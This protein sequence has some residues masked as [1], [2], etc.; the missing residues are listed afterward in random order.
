[1][2][3]GLMPCRPGGRQQGRQVSGQACMDTCQGCLASNTRAGI[4]YW[5]PC[6][7][8]RHAG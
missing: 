3:L 1:L 8:P 7:E 5:Q 4:S 2:R 6:S